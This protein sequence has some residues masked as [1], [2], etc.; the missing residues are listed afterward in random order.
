MDN[1]EPRPA[2]EEQ[3]GSGTELSRRENSVAH[4]LDEH[5]DQLLLTLGHELKTPITVIKGSIQLARHRLQAAGHEQEAG[6]LE[7]ANS[8]IDRLTALVDY[9]LRAGQLNGS[10]VALHLAR[11][12]LVQLVREVGITMQA[13]TGSHM[14]TVQAPQDVEIDGDEDRMRQ[15]VSNLISNAI[16]YSP[17]GSNVEITLRRTGGEAVLCVRDYGIGIPIEDR[18]RVFERFERATNVGHI[19]GFGLGLTMCRDIVNAHH[20]RLWVSDLSEAARAAALNPILTPNEDGRGSLFCL[21]LP[22]EQDARS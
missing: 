9:L 21:A 2:P 10:E 11:F 15:V 14:V 4:Q 13:L 1:S 7:V 17:A 12:D 5:Q 20:G 16:K 22:L 3:D 8:Q 19:P 6:W 18:D